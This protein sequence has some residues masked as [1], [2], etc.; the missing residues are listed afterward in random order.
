MIITDR[1]D[2]EMM[3]VLK[4]PV[5]AGVLDI[6]QGFCSIAHGSGNERELAKMLS[7]RAAEMGYQTSTDKAG[8]LLID[9][10]P[11]SGCDRAPVLMLQGHLDMVCAVAQ[12]GG[13]DPEKDPVTMVSGRDENSGKLIIRSDR[14]S[15]LGADC[16]IGDAAVLWLFDKEK[17]E[18][19]IQHGPVRILFT[20]EEE[21]G[22]VGAS[23]LDPSVF[24][25]VDYLINVD[26]FT[27]G[28]FIA[29]SA[30]GR[31]EIWR[32]RCGKVPVREIVGYNIRNTH[33]FELCLR[34]FRG[35]HSGFD[36]DKGRINA[37]KVMAE[38]LSSFRKAGV[39]FAL[40][41]FRG[42]LAHNVIPSSAKALITVRKG[43]LLTCQKCFTDILRKVDEEM[44]GRDD[45]RFTYSEVR[46]PEKAFDPETADSILGFVS[47]IKTGVVKYMDDFHDI[48]DSSCN[49][50]VIDAD[51]AEERAEVLLFER[52]MDRQAHDRLVEAHRAAGREHGFE[53]ELE[54]EYDAWIYDR[55]NPLLNLALESYKE[56]SGRDGEA[57]AVHIGIEPSVFCRYRPDLCMISAGTDLHDPHTVYERCETG[58]IRPFALT[59]RGIVERIAEQKK[60]E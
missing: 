50:G 44:D 40:S 23:S 4:E 53:P 51:A 31:R 7:D 25:P 19:E 32:R 36:I 6:F 45:G 39:G 26:G 8:N 22:M 57:Y 18:K 49:L 56:A 35:G 47:S 11:S 38:I 14:R 10:P 37:V 5:T 3:E 28:R 13:W 42:G 54:A 21:Q 17:Q 34:D 59:L 46:I 48:V 29:G 52:T 41:S 58:S 33:A 60:G 55:D 15:S 2:R 9:I 43:D 30:G 27:G 20:V 24:E 1:D 16:G 12:G